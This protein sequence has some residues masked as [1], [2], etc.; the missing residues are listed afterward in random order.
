MNRPARPAPFK[1]PSYSRRLV[2]WTEKH[3]PRSLADVIGNGPN[4]ALMR[5]WADSWSKGIP[6]QRALVLAGPP[7]TGKTSAALALGYDMGWAVIELN[8]SD[9]RNADRIRRVATAGAMHQTFNSDG[10]F[11]RTGEEGEGGGRKLIVLDEA[12]NLY[13]RLAGEN[14][15]GGGSDLSDR[16][17]KTQIIQTIRDS[18]Q[19]IILIVNDLYALQKGSGAAIRTLAQTLKWGRINVRSIPNALEKICRIEG[20]RVE[21]A[22]LEAIAAKAEGDM[23]AAVRD[24]ESISAGRDEVTVAALE[25]LGQRDRSGTM[26]DLVKHVLKQAPIKELRKESMEVDATPEDYVLWIDENLPKEYVHP[27]DLVAGYEMLSRADVFLG[28]TRRKQNYRLWAYAGDL[29]ILGVSAVRQH[30][31]PRGFVPF[32]F[33]QYL[34]KMSRSKGSRAVKNKL[35]DSLATATH[36]SRRKA[37]LGQVEPFTRIFGIDREFQVHQSLAMELEDDEIALLIDAKAKDKAVAEIRAQVTAM[38][39][40]HKAAGRP[41]PRAAPPGMGLGAFASKAEPST[42][43]AKPAKP[44]KSDAKPEAPAAPEPAVEPT[45]EPDSE[46]EKPKKKPAPSEGQTKLF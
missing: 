41:S 19:P 13:E 32:G 30:P 22:V 39:E 26:F 42:P 27:E 21:R 45:S 33:P 28:R 29:A 46:P 43:A 37:R 36:Q 15:A 8:A 7:G 31:G 23:R 16:G 14:A 38:E 3:R 12:D 6:K 18:K 4:V 17:G 5:K 44:G 2:D 9:A 20:K 25:S 24:L 35:A 34:S 10:S 11:H 40:E 1:S